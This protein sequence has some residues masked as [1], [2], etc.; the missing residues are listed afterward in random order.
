MEIFQYF[1]LHEIFALRRVCRYWYDLINKNLLRNRKELIICLVSYSTNKYFKREDIHECYYVKNYVKLIPLAPYHENLQILKVFNFMID[2]WFQRDFL[3][4]IKR[5]RSLTIAECT[6]STLTFFNSLQFLTRLEL[7]NLDINDEIV[8]QIAEHLKQLEHLNLSKNSMITGK[9]MDHLPVTMK[10]LIL[11]FCSL[12]IQN[13]YKCI[14]C[15]SKNGGHL[16][17]LNLKYNYICEDY[18]YPNPN[19]SF[20]EHLQHLREIKFSTKHIVN[21]ETLENLEKLV[22]FEMFGRGNEPLVSDTFFQSFFRVPFRRLR[23]LHLT[24]L[25]SKISD[26][27][28][29]NCLSM[30]ENIES[31]K[32]ISLN[33]LTK[34]SLRLISHLKSLRFL[35]LDNIRLDN[36]LAMEIIRQCTNLQTFIIEFND[37]Y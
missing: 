3:V 34:Q 22:I 15:L 12:N 33:T 21:D 6:L 30:C 13:L 19:N 29:A 2:D 14:E 28:F 8:R 18:P 25:T 31:L 27:I 16:E 17:V 11:T 20:A 24:S 5:L 4:H 1:S 37:L 26:E 23:K 32:L 9:Y 7:I 36:E 10:A 35:K